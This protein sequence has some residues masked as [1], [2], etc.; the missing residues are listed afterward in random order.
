M[1]LRNRLTLIISV[2]FLS[3]MLLGVAFL[4]SNARQRVT[5]EVRSSATLTWQLLNIVLSE[6]GIVQDPEQ[7]LQLLQELASLEDVRHLE[8]SISQNDRPD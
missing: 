8:I 4:I 7:Q 3:G 5:T 6:E 1:S 2:L